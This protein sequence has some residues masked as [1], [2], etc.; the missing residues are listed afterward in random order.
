MSTPGYALE[1]ILNVWTV[2]ALFLAAVGAA[3]AALTLGVA[4]RA[5]MAFTRGREARAAS[6]DRGHLLAL[7]V[8]VL[9]LVRFLAW[10]Q[11]YLVLDSYV[12]D[13][14]VFGVMCA[15]GVTRI[16]A[17][18]VF[19]LE[20]IKPA[21]MLLAGCWFVVRR[22][23]DGGRASLVWALPLGALALADCV[24][25][26]L[27]L[28]GEKAGRPMTCC[29]QFLDV[30]PNRFESLGA[31]SLAGSPAMTLAL[32]LGL[33]VATVLACLAARRAQRTPLAGLVALAAL[34][35]ACV[36]VTFRAWPDAVAPLVLGLPYHHCLYELLTDTPA[37]GPAALAAVLGGGALLWPL[38]L[39]VH[40]RGNPDAARRM[41][42]AVFGFAAVALASEGILV[43][44]HL[45]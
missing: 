15:Y 3:L 17:E 28:L 21:V 43:G 35:V 18:R 44:V 27:Y 11:F 9:V 34:G 13:L 25:E 7:I 8:S 16:D 24:L 22:A 12:P 4:A 36:V 23:T 33:L 5:L 6:D 41:Q 37:F 40:R 1:V 45:I 32:H 42:R 38:A 10:P 29:T 31:G 26:T 2:S 20:W 14:A 19:A 39:E 30:A